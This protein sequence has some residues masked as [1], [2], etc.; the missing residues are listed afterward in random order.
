MNIEFDRKI[1]LMKQLYSS[2]PKISDCCKD[3]VCFVSSNNMQY[4]RCTKC[5]A[6]CE[7][8]DLK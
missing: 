3:T 1:Q 6:P 8:Q 4:W 7:L 2:Q 5:Q